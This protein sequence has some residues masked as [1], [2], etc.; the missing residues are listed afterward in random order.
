MTMPG[1][2]LGSLLALFLGG[3]FHLWRGGNLGRLLIF[4]AFSLAGFWAG[5]Y[6]GPFFGFSLGKLGMINLGFAII[7]SLLFLIVGNWL[8]K[9]DR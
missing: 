1:F 2:L 9:L 7:G 4:L 3:V 8:T 6:L 5:H